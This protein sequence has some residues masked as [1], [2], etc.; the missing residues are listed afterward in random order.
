M[1]D[2]REYCLWNMPNSKIFNRHLPL[3]NK[4]GLELVGKAIETHP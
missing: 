3:V 1:K 2:H 4:T